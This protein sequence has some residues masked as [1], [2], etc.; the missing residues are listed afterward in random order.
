MQ[1]H[2]CTT[3]IRVH[4]LSPCSCAC[5]KSHDFKRHELS[6]SV[7]PCPHETFVQN[8][9]SWIQVSLLLACTHYSIDWLS[10][11]MA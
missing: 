5:F 2:A 10:A 11:L 3:I 7:I 4:V 1:L 9:D 8:N 6:T